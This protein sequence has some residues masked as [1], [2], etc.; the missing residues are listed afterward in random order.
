MKYRVTDIVYDTESDGVIYDATELKLPT[1]F[2]IELVGDND[3]ENEI[4]D[5]ISNQT[6]WCVGSYNYEIL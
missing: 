6:G 2:T 5:S 1:E 3:V 4:A